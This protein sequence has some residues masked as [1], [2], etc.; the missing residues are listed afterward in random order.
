MRLGF[1]Y[2]LPLARKS[3]GMY[4]PGYLAVFVDALAEQVDEL[5]LVLHE[6][7]GP[8]I[9]AADYRLRASNV[10]WVNLGPK[11]PAWHRSL[12]H[13]SVLARADFAELR[14]DMMLVRSPS[15]LA[16]YFGRIEA[17]RD[18]LAYM[19]VGDYGS[20]AA[21]I[22]MD[23]VRNL[24]V[25]GYTVWNDRLF[26]RGLRDQLVIVN[27]H[28]LYRTLQETTGSLF[29]VKTTT[30]VQ[31]D[32]FERVD[33]CQ[34]EPIRLLF[35]GRLIREK[36]LRELLLAAKRLRD[37]GLPV[38]VNL[39]GWEPDGARSLEEELT[40]MAGEL[41]MAPHLR[42]HGRRKVGQELNEMYRMA[43]VYVLPSYYKGEGFPRT[44]WEAMAN[45][46]PVVSTR[47]GSVPHYLRDGE[48]AVLV[49]PRD[50]EALCRG[51]RS[52]ITD[53]GLR[54]RLIRRGHELAR[55]NTLGVQAKKLVGILRSH[56]DAR[57]PA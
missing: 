7:T 55:E 33:T 37:D 14:L 1:Y 22:S 29:E 15:P 10:R 42:F 57:I 31:S 5:Y 21:D 27:S 20:A 32:F 39:V 46:V 26:K 56:L 19:V 17:L 54:R 16:P 2:H 11:R 34:E 48:D 45:S 3:G 52:V 28:A 41:G 18:R 44:I 24:A 30:L 43:D 47:I 8:E 12:F 25:R 38:E 40:R 51:I 50:V 36:G 35:T 13:R 6:A 9:A 49:E 53:R 23:S 4:L